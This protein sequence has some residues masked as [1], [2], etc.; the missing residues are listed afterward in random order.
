MQCHSPKDH[1]RPE[2]GTEHQIMQCHSNVIVQA[3]NDHCR[4]ELWTEHQ[5][6]QCHSPKDYCRPV[7]VGTG[8]FF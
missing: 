6:M 4:P 5:N 3:Y 1:S 2:L 7:V 8:A